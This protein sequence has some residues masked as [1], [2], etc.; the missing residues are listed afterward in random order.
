MLKPRF[1]MIH[2]SAVSYMANADQFEA[3]NNYHKAQWNFKSSMGFYLGY[4]Y[5]IAK[6]GFIKQARQEGEQTAACYQEN[7]NNG[8]CIHV[9]LDGNFDIEK[10]APE[11]IYA[12]RDLLRGLVKKYGIKKDNIVFHSAYAQK[13]CPGKNVDLLFVRS[14]VSSNVFKK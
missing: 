3:N 7:M 14:L 9:C 10:P 5:E 2:H 11:Q 1:I 12:L 8:Q 13:S 4:N 6:S